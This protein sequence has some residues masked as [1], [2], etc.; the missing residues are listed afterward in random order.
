[1]AKKKK[2]GF[3]WYVVVLEVYA[4]LVLVAAFFGLGW[5]RD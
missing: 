1:M 3:G 5:F 2:N 4:L